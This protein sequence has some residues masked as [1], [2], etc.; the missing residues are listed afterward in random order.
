M[1]TPFVY[2]EAAPGQQA[3]QY[4]QL[5]EQGEADRRRIIAQAYHDMSTQGP[6]M[7][8]NNAQMAATQSQMNQRSAEAAKDRD[9]QR[10]GYKSAE[11]VATGKTNATEDAWDRRAK[12][13]TDAYAAEVKRQAEAFF[14][15]GE[16]DASMMYDP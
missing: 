15:V 4:A 3:V 5:Q 7:A 11:A 1:A 6:E 12:A 14:Q 13:Q 2:R 16:T 10:E 9:L 8:R